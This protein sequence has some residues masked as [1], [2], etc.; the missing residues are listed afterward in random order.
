MLVHKGSFEAEGLTLVS[1]P[2]EAVPAAVVCEIV[3]SNG[4]AS[5]FLHEASD[6]LLVSGDIVPQG[7]VH[8][9]NGSTSVVFH[10]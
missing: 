4:V 1:E 6:H 8:C 10:S 7:E 9:H 5:A 3:Y 2:P